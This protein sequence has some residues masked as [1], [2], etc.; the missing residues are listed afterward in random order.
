MGMDI[1]FV[2]YVGDKPIY[3]EGD[4][5]QGWD[6]CRIILEMTR[7]WYKE[8]RD[9]DGEHQQ[10]WIDQVALERANAVLPWTLERYFKWRAKHLREIGPWEFR[11]CYTQQEAFDR[12][13]SF[14]RDAC[15]NGHGASVSF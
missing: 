8:S 4:E 12:A 13:R 7:L 15:L 9:S 14:I 2:R 5:V 10:I 6:R 3:A 1:S 11:Y